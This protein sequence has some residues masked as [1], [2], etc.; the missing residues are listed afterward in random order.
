MVKIGKKQD[1]KSTPSEHI[2]NQGSEQA[3]DLSV[4]EC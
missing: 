2:G 3:Y 1:M 4:L